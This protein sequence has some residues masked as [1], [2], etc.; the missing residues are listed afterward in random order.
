[1]LLGN[2]KNVDSII[3]AGY[4]NKHDLMIVPIDVPFSLITMNISYKFKN[5][6]ISTCVVLPC[7]ILK[8]AFYLRIDN[9]TF[10]S[11]WRNSRKYKTNTFTLSKEFPP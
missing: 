1:M 5:E 6:K 7:S 11:N 2:P 10:E 3:P 4:Q 9:N 8:F